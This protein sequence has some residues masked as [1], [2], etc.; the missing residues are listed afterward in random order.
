MEVTRQ[1]LAERASKKGL[2]RIQLT[3]CWAGQRLR[4]SSGQKVAPRDWDARQHR[5]KAKPG[6]F[7][8]DVNTVL[9]RYTD[10]A[11]AV[12]H[13]AKMRGQVLGKDAMRAAI[14]E[15]FEQLTREAAGLPD[16]PAPPTPAP[17]TVAEEM[18]HW[19]ETVVAA[20]ISRR[21]GRPIATKVV[22][23]HRR[24]AADL[25]SFAAAWPQPL[26]YP[27]IDARF[28]EAFRNHLLGVLGRGPGTYNHYLGLLRAFLLWAV[29]EG[30]P[31]NPRFKEVL[32]PVEHHTFVESFTEDE[33]LA[34]AAIDFTSPAVRAY[35]QAQFPEQ[36]SAGIRR[37]ITTEEHLRRLWLTRDKFLLCTYTA[38]RIGDADRLTPRQLH[39][40]VARVKAG[41]T[42]VTCIIPLVDDHVFQPARLLALH[43]G[44]DPR[45]CLPRVTFPYL[46]LPHVQHL[47]GITRL[48]VLFHT[49]RKTFATLKVAQGVPRSQVMMTTGHQTE[50]SFNHYLGVN[51]AELLD[52]YRRTARQST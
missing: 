22:Q 7:L 44:S 38:L 43:A 12:E 21:T 51:E 9:Q 35:V 5:A 32:Q 2:A 36:A 25:A 27:G 10:A 49:G 29:L 24:A 31:V 14:E 26:T 28:N 33:V 15:R 45:W 8:G 19:V 16:V 48:P 23:N 34:I 40:D 37:M 50:A 42:G 47:A 13:E 46:Y 3:F 52:W 18:A 39:G 4:L 17:R 11:T 6:T 20:R 30:H 1:L 41:K